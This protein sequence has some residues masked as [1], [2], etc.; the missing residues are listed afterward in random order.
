MARPEPNIFSQKCGNGCAGAAASTVISC[1][2]AGEFSRGEDSREAEH[3][4]RMVARAKQRHN[5]FIRLLFPHEHSKSVC[6]KL[7]TR[8][9]PGV[10]GTRWQVTALYKLG[11]GAKRLRKGLE[12]E[13]NPQRDDTCAESC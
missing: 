9:L 3:S 8:E 12:A 4:S 1:A 6:E 11:A 5:F 7:P 10:W 13:A 2:A